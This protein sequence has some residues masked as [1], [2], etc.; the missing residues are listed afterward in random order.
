MV[1]KKIFDIENPTETFSNLNNKLRILRDGFYALSDD[2]GYYVEYTNMGNHKIFELRDNVIYRFFSSIFHYQLMFRQQHVIEQQ[3][4]DIMTNDPQ[5]L[6]AFVR[7][8]NL[9]Y[10]YAEKEMS[11]ILDSIVFHLS[12]IYDYMSILISFI[13]IKDRDK[14]L[15][16][17]ALRR[18]ARDPNNEIGGKDIATIIDNVDRKFVNYLYTYRSELIHTTSDISEYA[19]EI[20]SENNSI[21]VQFIC[22]SRLRKSFKEMGENDS[23]YTVQYFGNW[24]IEETINTIVKLIYGLRN[25]VRDDIK[26][27]KNLMTI[28]SD[29]PFVIGA[30]R[31]NKMMSPAMWGEFDKEFKHLDIKN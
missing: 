20:H 11:S 7:P 16:W 15:K 29:K 8:K 9:H 14:K 25:E 2:Y 12:S 19:A 17:T 18:S 13:N 22:S 4:S 3:F 23:D 10:E 26:L 1:S 31:D 30:S 6:K 27:Y 24:I 21:S 5:R 28:P